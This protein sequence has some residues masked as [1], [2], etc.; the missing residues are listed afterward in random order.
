MQIK[1]YK[2]V[3]LKSGDVI[4]KNTIIE[5]VPIPD[6]DAAC[7]AQTPYGE[8]RMRYSSLIKPPTIKQL[9][10][11]SFDGVCETPLGNETEPDGNDEHGFPAWLRVLGFV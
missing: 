9:E 1:C 5:I 2:D 6:V 8:K 10:D 4:K 11:W 7:L 3:T